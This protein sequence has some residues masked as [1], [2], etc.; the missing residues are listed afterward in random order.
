MSLP[1]AT[2]FSVVAGGERLDRF[3]A[4]VLQV[5]RTVA[6]RLIGEGKVT[7]AGAC[8]RASLVAARGMEIAVEFP[9]AAPR[10]IRP[11]DIPLSVV[12]E[13]AEL[14]VIDK[15]AGLVVHPAPGHWD[16]T[17]V[18]ALAARGLDLAGGEEGRPG[19]VHRL[20]KD[21]SGL[22]VVAKTARAHERLGHALASRR[23]ERRY[24]ALA[25]GHLDEKEERQISLALVRNPKDR[26]R[27]MVARSGGKAAVTLVRTVARG[28][29]ADLVSCRLHTGRTHQIRVHLQAIGHPVV[30]DDTYGGGVLGGAV[31]RSDATRGLAQRLAS[32]TPRQ[33]LH[34]A[35]L[36]LRHPMSGELLDLRSEWPLDLRGAL[37]TALGDDSLLAEPKPLEYLHF[38]ASGGS[39]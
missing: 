30:G 3:L 26:K 36:R 5:S 1:P 21:T 25:W 9:D 15:P 2:R 22:L 37:A 18:N 10:Q 14:A 39:S 16:D 8:A 13:D 20:D 24:A 12:Y 33:A 17:L 32:G 23:I 11:A 31:K 19:I 28:L 35:W 38:F 27:M 7:V 29:V 34:A 4:G 6:A